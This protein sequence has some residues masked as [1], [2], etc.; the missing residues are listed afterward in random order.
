MLKITYALCRQN[1]SL[2]LKTLDQRVR[3]AFPNNPS[4]KPISFSEENIEDNG[5]NFNIKVLHLLQQKPTSTKDTFSPLINKDNP[6]QNNPF[7]PPFEPGAFIGD[8]TK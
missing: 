4:I 7:L 1:Y 3:Y 2:F 8:V 5:I 6:P